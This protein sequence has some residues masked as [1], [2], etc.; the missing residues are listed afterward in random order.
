MEV[1]QD[2][3]SFAAARNLE[4]AGQLDEAAEAY[5]RLLQADPTDPNALGRILLVYRRQKESR[6]ELAVIDAALNAY[7]QRDKATRE[8]WLK[9]HPKAAGA[10]KAILKRLGT[11]TVSAFGANPAVERLLKRKA[12]VENKLTGKKTARKKKVKAPPAATKRAKAVSTAN[13]QPQKNTAPTNQKVRTEANPKARTA[14][15]Q[16]ARTEGFPKARTAANRKAASAARRQKQQEQQKRKV[17]KRKAQA[18][19]KKLPSVFIITIRY[20]APQQEIDAALPA[21]EKFLQTHYRK[22]QFLL[23]GPQVPPTGSI[24]IAKAKNRQAATR[25][26]NQ[27]PL[28]KKKLATFDLAEFRSAPASNSHARGKAPKPRKKSEAQ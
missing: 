26:M 8:A 1:A 10:G 12:V 13:K 14:A 27:D 28:I 17:Q 19:Q 25:L 2:K 6:K 7:Q 11:A 24:I 4:Q 22:R 21:H 16:K 15:N 18:E 20:L 23:S 5:H 9:A 3:T